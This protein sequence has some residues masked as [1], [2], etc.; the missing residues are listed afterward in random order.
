MGVGRPLHKVT[1]RTKQL[2]R[3]HEAFTRRSMD[4]M[5]S[6][7]LLVNWVNPIHMTFGTRREAII[8]PGTIVFRTYFLSAAA[9]GVAKD[10]LSQQKCIFW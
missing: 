2:L 4:S 3:R 6:P 5:P 8:L 7:W 9:L 10:V 1:K